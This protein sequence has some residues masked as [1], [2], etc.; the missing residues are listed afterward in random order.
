MSSERGAL[1]FFVRISGLIIKLNKTKDTYVFNDLLDLT[2]KCEDFLLN[3]KA[4]AFEK[5][6]EFHLKLIEKSENEF[7]YEAYEKLDARIQLLRLN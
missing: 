3:K 5:N 6:S 4:K 2:Q 7:L 1:H